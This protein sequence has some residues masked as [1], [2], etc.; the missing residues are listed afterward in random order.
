MQI[1]NNVMQHTFMDELFAIFQKVST[2][3]MCFS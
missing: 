3:A 1:L 2:F